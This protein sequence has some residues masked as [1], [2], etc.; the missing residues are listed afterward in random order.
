MSSLSNTTLRAP[1]QAGGPGCS[2]TFLVSSQLDW[3]I[4]NFQTQLYTFPWPGPS[5]L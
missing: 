3:L 2:G 4:S 5:P 1:K